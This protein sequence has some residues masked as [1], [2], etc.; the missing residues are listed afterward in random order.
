MITN[1]RIIGDVHRHY[2][3]YHRLLRKAKHT[4]QVG[5]FGFKYETLSAVDARQH[6]VLG[7]NHDNY[8][9][10]SRWPHFLGNFGIHSVEGFGD[11]FFVRGGFSTDRDTRTEGVDW[12]SDEEL[13]MADCYAALGEYSRVK[14]RFVVTHECPITVV[15]YATSSLHIIPSR[16]NQLLE[17]MFAVHKPERWVFGHHHRSLD[18]VIDGTH[19]TCLDELECLDF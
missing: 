12:W 4:L 7:G 2:G 18:R 9:E 19:F 6:R 8:D 5:D 15:P 10:M 14:P 17:R 3:P 13:G 11:I 16:T 1:F